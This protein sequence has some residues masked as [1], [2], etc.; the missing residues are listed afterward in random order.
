M[1]ATRM[2]LLALG[3]GLG[4]LGAWGV[5]TARAQDAP[6]APAVDEVS[7]LVAQL[8]DADYDARERA[9]KRLVELGQAAVAALTGAAD[10]EDAE[11]QR[12]ARRAL[13][14][15]AD[16]G[17]P[18][19]PDPF[20]VPPGWQRVPDE[21]RDDPWRDAFGDRDPFAEMDRVFKQLFGEL[22]LEPPKDPGAGPDRDP[23]D[24][25]DLFRG[26][27]PRGGGQG[28]RRGLDQLLERLREGGGFGQDPFG[29]ADP[30]GQLPR[31]DELFRESRGDGKAR[32]G[33]SRSF[34]MND[35]RVTVQ[36][37]EDGTTITVEQSPDGAVKVTVTEPDGA[38]GTKTRDWSAAS[39]AELKQKAPEAATHYD[40]AMGGV[41][42]VPPR[43]V[44]WRRDQLRSPLGLRIEPLGA[45]LRSQLRLT[46]GEG[47]YVA[48]VEPEGWAARA[49]LQAYDVV[50]RV[51]DKTVGRI[52]DLEDERTRAADDENGTLTL[53]VIRT[54]ER[55]TLKAKAR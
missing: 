55:L 52:E 8:G 5:E 11:V 23:D 17:K 41:R 9:E 54:G 20:Q 44:E 26:L 53:T 38:G 10:S 29:G 39:E 40:R 2:S 35:G 33:T 6:A 15:I 46:D 22:G 32:R 48:A 3:L 45:A 24:P 21:R 51:N 28:L 31:L 27:L 37:I 42:I 16:Q 36:L 25:F 34:S 49:G 1:R 47:L 30:F 4:A 19:R 50:I 18:H 13:R 14:R 43:R 12:R 7:R